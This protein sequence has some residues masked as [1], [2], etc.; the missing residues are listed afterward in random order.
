VGRAEVDFGSQGKNL[1]GA[2]TITDFSGGGRNGNSGCSPRP[3]GERRL[4]LG[5]TPVHLGRFVRG[6]PKPNRGRPRPNRGSPAAE[7]GSPTTEP[8]P[9]TAPWVD[10]NRAGVAHNRTGFDTKT[11]GCRDKLNRVCH[12]L[13]RVNKKPTGGAQIRTGVAQKQNRGCHKLTGVEKIKLNR[14]RPK[15]NRGSQKNRRQP[16]T[17]PTTAPSTRTPNPHI[18]QRVFRFCLNLLETQRL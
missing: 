12:K 9:F 2:T 11:A 3:R 6:R 13:T 15:P 18:F 14:R 10:R 17:R 8:A 1:F 4:V 16:Q 7:P 5:A